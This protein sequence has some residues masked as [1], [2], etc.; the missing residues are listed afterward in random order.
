MSS[1]IEDYAIIGDTETVALV[2]RNG[3]I[4]WMCV[5]R[6]DGGAC[7]ASLL[8]GHEHGRWRLHPSAQID[9]VDRQYVGDTVVLETVFHT[10]SGS[11]ALIDFMPIRD[12]DATVVRIVEGR[13]GTVDFM[14]ELIVRFDYGYVVPWVKEYD[15]GI[16]ALGGSDAL[17]LSTP[18][19]LKGRDLATF[20]EFEVKQGERVPFVLTWF[21]SHKPIPDSVDPFE[22]LEGTKQWWTDWASR[23]TY[24]GDDKD[25]VLRSLLTLKAMTYA[26][27]GGIVAAATTSLPE[28]LGGVRNWDYRFC[29]LRDAT[30]T[31]T[32]LSEAG[33]VDEAMAW[34]DWLRRAVAGSPKKMQIM[35]GVGGERRL[36]EV[37]LSW[38]PGYEHSSPV[39]IGNAASEQFQLD[40][41]GEVMDMFL[42][43]R[44]CLGHELP[45]DV[46]DLA[47]ILVEHVENVW[48]E[49]D[50]GI[51]EVRGPRRHFVHSKVMAWVA[52]DRWV[53]LCEAG[54]PNEPLAKWHDLRDDMHREI[55]EKGYNPSV[56]AFTQYYGA[57]ELD[58]SCL[59]L[60]LVGFL[61][62]DDPR[63]AG[64]VEAIER[65]LLVD[66][67]VKR[68][69]TSAVHPADGD[70]TTT[71]D[72]LPPGEGAFL[73]TTF[74]LA[75]NLVLQ[76]RKDDGRAIFDRLAGLA[77]DLGLLAEEYDVD[78]SRMVGNFPQ[79]FSHVGLILTAM[80]LSDDP[81]SPAAHHCEPV[82]VR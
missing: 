49:P 54:R 32:A 68:Y 61:P 78:L 48:T 44:H 66:G 57:T 16:A 60:A 45:D 43:S 56:G 76:G 7:F 69:D 34:S 19:E 9:R 71:V 65:D 72:G 20:S 24:K 29:W 74:W 5:P 70:T 77:N 30:F 31:L 63:I 6:F 28:S 59:R 14:M 38:L 55:C 23:C 73:L 47:R 1:L 62:A 17:R 51:W 26:P 27:T 37:E 10:P 4:D 80:N 81:Y 75:D 8:G 2:A 52:V 46:W 64:T 21:P 40:V 15:S 12:E 3:S 22:S 36:Q 35:Y 53:Q 79:A 33:Y 11:A 67:F 25:A 18:V 41:Y 50:E 39:R 42:H 58:A 82:E 13:S